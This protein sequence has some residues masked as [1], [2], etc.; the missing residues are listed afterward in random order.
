[1]IVTTNEVPGQQAKADQGLE[2]PATFDTLFQDHWGRVYGLLVRLVGDQDEAEDLALEAFWRLYRQPP[3]DQQANLAGWL[4]R[5]AT[6]LGFNALRAVKRRRRYED[7]AG[8]WVLERAPESNPA[9]EAERADERA[10]VRQVLAQMKPRSAEVL[11]L[12]HSGLSYAEVAATVGVSV[13]SVGTL[14]A[15]AEEEFEQRYRALQGGQDAS[16]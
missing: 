2:P 8:Q 13:S 9:T 14:L 11:M 7:E 10:Q 15:R 1:V 16:Q 3:R 12:R 4:Y 5:V 6:N